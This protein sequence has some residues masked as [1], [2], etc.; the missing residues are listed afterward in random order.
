MTNA[1][2]WVIAYATV[3]QPLLGIADCDLTITVIEH[4]EID[5]VPVDGRVLPD[6]HYHRAEID[7]RA[8]VYA[9]GPTDAARGL[10]LHELLHVA[11]VGLREA[12]EQMVNMLVPPRQRRNALDAGSRWEEWTIT[13]LQRGL[14]P[15]I[16]R[17][18][19][20]AHPEYAPAAEAT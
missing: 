5:G 20:E 18:F 2:D 11:L 1:P 9:D 8:S 14:Q 7:L 19:Y 16:D 13:R 3:A 10:L 17:A 12:N 15:L 6:W 4:P